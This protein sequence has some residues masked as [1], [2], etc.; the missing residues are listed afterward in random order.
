MLQFGS[1]SS[2]QVK[3][4]NAMAEC[5][6]KAAD[7]NSAGI[8]VVLIHTTVGHNFKEILGVAAEQCPNATVVGCTGSGVI[9]SEGVSEAMRALAIMTIQGPEVA[10]VFRDGLE[11]VIQRQGNRYRRG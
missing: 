6:E 8:D 2:G 1:G 7:G 10:A 9:H 4:A 3:S 5:I 11:S